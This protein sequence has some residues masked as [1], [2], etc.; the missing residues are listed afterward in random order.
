M[1]DIGHFIRQRVFA[2]NISDDEIA[3]LDQKSRSPLSA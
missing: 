1:G 2:T 3:G